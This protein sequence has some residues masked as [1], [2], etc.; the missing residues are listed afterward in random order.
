MGWFDGFP[1]VSKDER[2][3]RRKD[4]EKRI[5]PFG[6][7]EQ[8][9]KLA[10]TLKGLF[11]D[12]DQM[13]AMFTFFDAKDAFTSKDDKAAGEV[14]A[15]ARLRRQRWVNGRTEAIMLRFVEMECE[16]ESLEDYPSAEDVMKGLFED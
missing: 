6:I 13:D 4:F 16:V 1:F 7:D 11:P 10:A 14:A 15:R 3:R 2:E 8:R 9:K 5:A 12:V